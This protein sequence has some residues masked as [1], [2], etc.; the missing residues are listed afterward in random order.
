VNKNIEAAPGIGRKEYNME[1]LLKTWKEFLQYMQDNRDK[2]R[3]ANDQGITK[4][5]QP[6]FETFMWWLDHDKKL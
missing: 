4:Q 6:T 3:Y 2:Y 1:E 5:I